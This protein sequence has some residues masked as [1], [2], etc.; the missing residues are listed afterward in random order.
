MTALTKVIDTSVDN[1]RSSDN[2]GFSTEIDISA[3]D[4]INSNT[5][6]A[7][8]DVSKISNM[9]DFRVWSSM[10]ISSWIEMWPCG[11]ATFSQVSVLMDMEPVLPWSQPSDIGSNFAL[12]AM[13]LDKFDESVDS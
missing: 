7:G 2:T 6:V 9:S 3:F 12:F 10:D 1:E 11:L 8:G 4:L 13:F 5:I